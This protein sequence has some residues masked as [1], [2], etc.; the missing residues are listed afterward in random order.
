MSFETKDSGKRE[1]FTSGMVRD[2]QDG[3]TNFALVFSGP[4]LERWAALLTRGAVKYERDN[5]MKA[6]GNAE[7]QRFQESAA[8]HF[9]QWMRGD[10]DEDH[11]AAVYFNLNGAEYVKERLN[12]Q[13]EGKLYTMDEVFPPTEG[14][15]NKYLP[16]MYEALLDEYAKELKDV[17]SIKRWREQRTE[18]F[19]EWDAMPSTE[20]QE[21]VSG[22]PEFEDFVDDGEPVVDGCY[23]AHCETRRAVRENRG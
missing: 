7:F 14:P 5:W 21:P 1:Q 11:A 9:A 22:L 15:S 18:P 17:E 19:K 4:M 3:K 2:T 20:R 12:A 16:D 23:C 8:R 10:T 6:S 13:C